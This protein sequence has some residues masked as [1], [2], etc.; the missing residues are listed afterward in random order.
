MAAVVH[1]PFDKPAG[2][3][4]EPLVELTPMQRVTG[5][6]ITLL[7]R[8]FSGFTVRWID[9]QPDVCQRVYLLITPAIW[10]LSCYGLHCRA[11]C[12]D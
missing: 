6:S 3:A 12:G 2:R 1:Q 7:A 4:A 10:M 8:F 5:Q 9:C 11:N